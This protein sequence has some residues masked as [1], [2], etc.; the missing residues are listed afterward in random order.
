MSMQVQDELAV[1]YQEVQGDGH[2]NSMESRPRRGIV[3][4]ACFHDRR[5]FL[6]R[7]SV[8]TAH[9]R[10]LYEL[11]IADGALWLVPMHHEPGPIRFDDPLELV[12]RF[13]FVPMA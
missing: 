2:E 3:S 9:G 8:S 4:P 12:G 13:S 6:R 1:Q 10:G 5:G 11:L 7:K